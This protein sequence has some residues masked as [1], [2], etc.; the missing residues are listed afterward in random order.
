M[1]WEQKARANWLR[2][3]D[4]NSSFFHKYATIR[5]REN[6]ISKLITEDGKEITTGAEI[7]E[8]A[9]IFFKELFT[10]KGVTNPDKVLEGIEIREEEIWKA[11]KEMGPTKAPGP[12]GFPALFYQRKKRIGQKG[13]I[14]VKVDMSKA[15]DRMECDFVKEM[16]L[17]MGFANEGLS[18]LLRSTKK[19]D[20]IK[21]AKASR[22][23]PEISHLLFADDCIMFGEATENGAR[24]MK[25]IL[26]EHESCSGQ[27]INFNKSIIFYSSNTSSEKREEVSSVLGVRSSTCPEKYL[28]LPNVVGRQKKEAFQNL[29][30]RIV[31]RIDGWSTRLLSQG[32]KEIFIKSLY[33][34]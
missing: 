26:R 8:T 12:D 6:S 33:A 10:S 3:G 17:K 20:L 5:R 31:K 18:S 23:G 22:K 9:T 30:D 2:F 24:I 21:R 25:D 11:L 13:Y 16:M 27:C 7:N 4:K 28:G 15:Y 19:N 34:K 32:G 1:F 29:L 14:A